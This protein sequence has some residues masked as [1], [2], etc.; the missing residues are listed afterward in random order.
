ML[1]YKLH[2]QKISDKFGVFLMKI[3]QNLDIVKYRKEIHFKFFYTTDLS[4]NYRYPKWV[5][6]NKILVD[7]LKVEVISRKEKKADYALIQ[8]HGGAYIY[9]FNNTYRRSAYKYLKCDENIAVYSPIY[10]LAPRHPFPVALNEVIS[11]YKYLLGIGYDSQHIL[12][13]GD[14]AGGGL[15]L[16]VALY[17]KDHSIPLPKAII[18]MSA[19]TNLAMNGTSH[20]RNFKVDPMFGEGKQPLNVRA[21]ARRHLLTNPY[22]SPKYGDYKNFTD[23]LMFV[24]SHELIESDTLDV[25]EKAKDTNEVIVH[26][27]EGMF[28]VFPFGFGKMASSRKAWK[29]IKNYINEKTR[30]SENDG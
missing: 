9:G 14:S 1:Y 19:W 13:A 22:V 17:L 7:D 16:A 6:F 5:E 26:N 20:K 15:A 10:S 2:K 11:L 18:T 4:E 24:G 12:F 29:I 25:A 21:Y 30:G 3:A 27:F 28:H 23:L 8:L